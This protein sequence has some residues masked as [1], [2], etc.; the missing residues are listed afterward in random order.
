MSFLYEF[1]SYFRTTVTVIMTKQPRIARM[2]RVAYAAL[3]SRLQ[4]ERAKWCSIGAVRRVK[5]RACAPG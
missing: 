1:T 2:H 3:Q 4:M 5:D